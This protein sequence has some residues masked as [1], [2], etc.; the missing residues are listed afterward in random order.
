MA[1]Q[2]LPEQRSKFTD[3][4]SSSTEQVSNTEQVSKGGLPPLMGKL[5]LGTPAG[6]NQPSQPVLAWAL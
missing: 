1:G 5:D 6:V 4:T 2:K 3:R